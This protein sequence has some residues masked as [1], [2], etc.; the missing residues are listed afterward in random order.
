MSNNVT[1]SHD[2]EKASVKVQSASKSF[3]IIHLLFRQDNYGNLIGCLTQNIIRYYLFYLPSDK[4]H[5]DIHMSDSVNVKLKNTH[6]IK[7]NDKMQNNAES[8]SDLLLLQ[9]KYMI[10]SNLFVN[11]P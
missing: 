4:R 1:L 11:S 10:T 5:F 7:E 6:N 2:F 8:T 9:N 3:R